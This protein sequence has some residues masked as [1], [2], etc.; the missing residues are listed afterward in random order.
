MTRKSLGLLSA[1][2]GLGIVTISAACAGENVQRR[3]YAVNQSA[4]D[5]GSISVYDIDA[6]HRLVKTIT[7]VADVRNVKGVVAS[8][9]TGKLYVA[10]LDAADTGKIF[11]LN[12]QDEAIV[13][14]R[15]VDPGVDRLAI[16]PNGQLL[17]VPTGED[18]T[19]DHINVLD[20]MTGSLVRKVYFSKRSHDTLYPL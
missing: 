7:T 3:I 1:L 18:G 9:I 15:A 14:N 6:G 11:C 13:W 2:A 16:S 12:V 10:Y 5:R 19:A 17:Y 20:A 4:K 8:A